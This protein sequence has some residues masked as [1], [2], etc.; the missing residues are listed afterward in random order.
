MSTT[1]SSQPCCDAYD[2]VVGGARYVY[3][4]EIASGSTLHELDVQDVS[5]LRGS[6]LG[7][8]EGLAQ[9]GQEGP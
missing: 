3:E 7:E 2:L 6:R 4:R 1:S 5:S 8:L 9:R